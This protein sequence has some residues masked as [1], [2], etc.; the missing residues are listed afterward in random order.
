[1]TAETERTGPASAA[2]GGVSGLSWGRTVLRLVIMGV[3]FVCL[4]GFAAVLAELTLTPSPVS[5]DMAGSNLRPGHSL[6]QYAE[7]YTFLA[8]CKQIGGNLLMGAPFGVI[9]PLLMPPRHRMVRVV[10]LTAVV[11]ALVEL[12]QGA[13]V[14]GR[15]FDVDDVILNTS[16]ALIAYLLLG[17]RISRRFHM[18]SAPSP[19]GAKPAAA[20][21]QQKPEQKPEAEAKVAR[22]AVKPERKAGRKAVKPERKAAPA[23]PGGRLSARLR[24]SGRTAARRLRRLRPGRR[25]APPLP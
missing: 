14:E 6:R 13:M 1:M 19:R 17:R 2:P 16:G 7:D 9:L 25:P 18:L 20:K 3:A 23:K 22:K 24:L 4:V 11:M 15:A 5:A 10:L 8:A 12:A 21:P